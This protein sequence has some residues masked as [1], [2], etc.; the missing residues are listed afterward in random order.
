MYQSVLDVEGDSKYSFTPIAGIVNQFALS[1]NDELQYH[2]SDSYPKCNPKTR[3]DGVAQ[4]E[5][6]SDEDIDDATK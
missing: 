6:M 4:M 1:T 2:D 3:V 5:F